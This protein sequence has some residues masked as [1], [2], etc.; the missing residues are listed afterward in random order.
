MSPRL[1]A[2]AFEPE[3]RPLF[4]PAGDGLIGGKPYSEETAREID[5]EVKR[6]VDETEARVQEILTKRDGDLKAIAQRLLD[7]EVLEGDEL[8]ALLRDGKAVGEGSRAG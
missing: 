1:G 4:L 8:R 6:I 2:L 5:E 7:K 3:R